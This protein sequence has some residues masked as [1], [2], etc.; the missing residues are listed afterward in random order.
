[1]NASVDEPDEAIFPDTPQTNEVLNLKFTQEEILRAIRGLNNG[2]AAGCDSI[3][4]EYI[5]TTSHI[6]LPLYESFFNTILDTGFFPE[7]WS[8]GCIH[9]IYKNKGDRTSPQ[10][11]RPITIL[12]CLR[13]LFTAILNT[14]LDQYLE[15]NIILLENQAG[16][17]K[18]YSTLD[19]IFTLYALNEILKSR[20]QK[21]FCCFVDFSSAFDSVWRAGLWHKLLRNGIDGKVFKVIYNMYNDIKSCVSV[22]GN[23]SPFFTSLSGVRQGENLSPVLFSIYLNDLDDY[24][25]QNLNA[26]IQ[27]DFDNEYMSVMT[28]LVVL[29]YADDTIILASDENDLQRSLDKFYDYCQSW[30]LTV[31][32]NKT[33]VLIFGA[34]KTDSYS[35]HL[36]DQEIEITDKYKYLGIYFSQSRSF[37]NARKHVVEQAKKAMHLL[38]S[39]INNLN[40]PI[41]LQLKLFDHTVL[42]I[43]TYACEIFSFENLDMLEKVHTSFLRKI[44]KSK[45]STPLY[46]LYAE[47]GRYPLEH[48]IKTQT[49]GFWLRILL[50]KQSKISYLMYQVLHSQAGDSSRFKW[51]SNV[52]QILCNAGRNDVWLNQNNYIPDNIKFYVKQN[53]QDQFIQSWRT[54]LTMS[55]KGKNYNVYKDSIQLEPYILALPY[56]LYINMIRFRTGNH[57]LPIEIGRWNNVDIDDRKCNL[58]TSN[59]IGDEF[60]YLLQCPY[61]KQDRLRLIPACYWER[62]NILKYRNLLCSNNETCL[63]NLSK[64]MGIIMKV[65]SF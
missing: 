57:K 55:S 1:M 44:T 6:F 7:Q 35:F 33:K 5:K 23:E 56:K 63:V 22:L 2:K 62:P 17:R 65:F 28:R 11:Y 14:R 25:S 61:F 36:G 52:K 42:P 49:I 15:E 12:S 47:L 4:N 19:H 58:C 20:K 16:F 43:L 53:L 31:N 9:P 60:H 18:Q 37:L 13:K 59:S 48:V 27:I 30:K 8:T 45:Q 40:L 32:I 54:N 41:D 64:F 39:R 50:G 29:L 46:M 26:G 51:I 24:L 3:L 21:L 10:N 38:Y 34:R